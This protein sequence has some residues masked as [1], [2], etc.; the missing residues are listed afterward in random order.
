MDALQVLVVLECLA[1]VGVQLDPEVLHAFVLQIRRWMGT[2]SSRELGRVV[3]AVRT[4]YPKVLPGRT[5]QQLVGELQRRQQYLELQ[6][7]P[8]GG[9]FQGRA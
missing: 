1:A 4:M 3:A 7:V 9:L 5:V 8:A 2:W 6:E